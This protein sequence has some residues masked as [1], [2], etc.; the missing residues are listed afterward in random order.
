MEP[1]DLMN[2]YQT[3]L[4]T[5][6]VGCQYLL[7]H[8]TVP[9]IQHNPI[10]IVHHSQATVYMLKYQVPSGKRPT[11]I[12]LHEHHRWLMTWTDYHL[13]RVQAISTFGTQ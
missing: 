6:E 9:V 7:V 8:S 1:K 11:F 12:D 5:S 13:V 10:S 4:G 2:Q 3:Q